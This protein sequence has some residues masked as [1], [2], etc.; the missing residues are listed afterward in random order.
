MLITI[1][2]MTLPICGML[3]TVA[4]IRLRQNNNKD[5]LVLHSMVIIFAVF[6]GG[7]NL[8]LILSNTCGKPE[9]IFSLSLLSIVTA[10]LTGY[11]YE[12]IC[13]R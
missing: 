13:R 12:A 5:H 10:V 7:T 11:F 3:V 8:M 1:A 2:I 9:L 6:S 4:A